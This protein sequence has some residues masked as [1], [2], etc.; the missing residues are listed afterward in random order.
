MRFSPA[1]VLV[2]ITALASSP[3]SAT[4][5]DAATSGT[6]VCPNFCKT[7][8]VCSGCIYGICLLNLFCITFKSLKPMSIINS[9]FQ[10]QILYWDRLSLVIQKKRMGHTARCSRKS[11]GWTFAVHDQSVNFARS[12]SAT[13]HA[14]RSDLP[15]VRTERPPT[16]QVTTRSRSIMAKLEKVVCGYLI[17]V[18]SSDSAHSDAMRKTDWA[19]KWIPDQRSIFGLTGHSSGYLISVPSSDSAHSDAM[20]KTDWA[21]KWIPDQRSI[22]DSAHS[23]AMCKTDWAL[24]WIPDQRSIFDSAHSDAMRKTDWALKWIPDQRSIF[25]S[26]HSDAMRKTDWALKWIPDQRSIFDS[27]HSDAMRKTD[28]ALKWI[29]DQRSIFDS[30]HSDAMRKTDWALKWIPDQRSIF[31]SAHSDAMRK[32]DWAL[33]WIPDQRSIFRLT[34]LALLHFSSTLTSRRILPSANTSLTDWALKWIPD[35]H[36]IFDI[37]SSVHLRFFSG[38]FASLDAL[39]VSLIGMNAR[40][41][42]QYIEF[43]ADCLL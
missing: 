13:A 40:L 30:A 24:K 41:I 36:S 14:P 19:L 17:S 4:P 43:V 27:A 26:A 18:P 20:R 10:I 38:S 34:V 25:D 31:D 9:R 15:P 39:A 6:D 8:D 35:Q 22:F 32:T 29:P 1:F 11:E 7:D 28:W 23:D 3:I 37:L 12:A 5:T 42:W 21:L 33:K 16:P 2:V